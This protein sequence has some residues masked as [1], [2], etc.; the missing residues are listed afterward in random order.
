MDRKRN[1]KARGRR[2]LRQKTSNSRRGHTVT[3]DGQQ[4]VNIGMYQITPPRMRVRFDYKAAGEITS[5]G[6]Q[7]SKYW[8]I[9]GCYGIDPSVG[10]LTMTGFNQWMALYGTYHVDTCRVKLT[11]INNETFPVRIASCFF[12]A[13][14]ATF[15]K[16]Q[17]GNQHAIEHP[18]LGSISGMGRTQINRTVKLASLLNKGAY[19][20]SL[21]QYYGTSGTN[22]ASL[23]SFN[24]CAATPSLAVLTNGITY[25][26][27]F[28]LI[29]DLS[30][31]ITLAQV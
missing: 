2:T 31:P 7:A 3:N 21:Q 13:A 26:V 6:S 22:P 24:I 4:I 18:M 12:P 17:W 29:T 28:D 16:D 20:G 8:N 11:V 30:Y 19:D 10:N 9:N 1:T 25:R 15:T 5:G 27:E 23:I 14:S